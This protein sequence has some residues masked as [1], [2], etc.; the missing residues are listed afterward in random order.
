MRSDKQRVPRSVV[1][2]RPPV[3]IPFLLALA[4]VVALRAA[5]S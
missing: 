2:I 4:S 1:S 3:G 5:E